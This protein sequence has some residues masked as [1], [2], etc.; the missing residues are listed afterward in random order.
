MYQKLLWLL[1][2]LLVLGVG[3]WLGLVIPDQ[4]WAQWDGERWL[5]VAESWAVLWRG[6]P[7][8]VLG[9]LLGFFGAGTFLALTLPHARE[10][11]FKAEIARLIR[12]R[13]QAV[14][15]AEQRVQTR[16][17]AAQERETRALQAQRDAVQAQQEADAM[18]ESAEDFQEQTMQE[19]NQANLRARNAIHAAERIKRRIEGKKRLDAGISVP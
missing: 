17:Q 14:I 6:W 15:E 3:F 10:A 11:D 12:Q 7:L 9:G 8:A 1:A 5:I 18:W 4:A 13:D 16:E 2:M 19:L